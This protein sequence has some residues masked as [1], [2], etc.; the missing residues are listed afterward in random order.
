[1]KCLLRSVKG[2]LRF[3][4]LLLQQ[5]NFRIA[6][7]YRACGK[8]YELFFFDLRGKLK[9]RLR[10]KLNPGCRDPRFSRILN[11]SK[12][13]ENIVSIDRLHYFDRDRIFINYFSGEKTY[14]AV[15]NS[16]EERVEARLALK[17][18]IRVL[19]VKDRVLYIKKNS[20][21]TSKAF[22]FAE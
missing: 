18:N 17:E 15:V 10:V 9:R 6:A 22:P 2:S 20:G 1:M 21:R 3:H 7:S 12:E 4:A 14:I 11:K 16:K 13:K 5:N 8:K 19:S